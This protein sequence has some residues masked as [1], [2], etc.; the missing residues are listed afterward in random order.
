MKKE[1]SVIVVI[2]LVMTGLLAFGSY[3]KCKLVKYKMNKPEIRYEI[4]TSNSV[5][6]IVLNKATGE[7]WI[8]A[9]NEEGKANWN[10]LTFKP[11]FDNATAFTP[12]IAKD[13]LNQILELTKK[14]EE[15]E[16]AA[17]AKKEE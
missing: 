17:A 6:P 13:K 12:E 4:Y 14:Q 7:T 15:E 9:V 10:P 16:A 5:N 8:Y 3:K 1:Y 2:L 11:W